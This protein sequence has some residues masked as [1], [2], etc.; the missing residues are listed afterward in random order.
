MS[1]TRVNQFCSAPDKESELFAFLQSLNDYITSSEGC[2]SY[3][4]LQDL[5]DASRFVVI[6]KWQNVES[7]Q[8]SVANFPKDEMM[9]AMPLFSGAPTG[10]Y[11]K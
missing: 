5:D 11:Y 8:A 2:I 9:A 10:S 1:I 7:H 4:V 3:E 6:E